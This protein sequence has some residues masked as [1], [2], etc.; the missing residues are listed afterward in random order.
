ML[1]V[2]VLAPGPSAVNVVVVPVV[3]VVVPVTGATVDDVAAVA[4]CEDEIK[5]VD[6]CSVV[7][8]VPSADSF[9]WSRRSC[10]LRRNC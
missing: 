1:L 5:S 10:S 2:L 9:D 6:C 7:T 4:L 8:I 3:V